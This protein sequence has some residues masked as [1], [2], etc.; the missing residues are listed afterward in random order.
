MRPLVTVAGRLDEDPPTASMSCPT[1]N[2][3]ARDL[4]WGGYGRGGVWGWEELHDR[5]D[6]W[7]HHT[8]K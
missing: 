1:V 4:G 3:R 7:D 2:A 6:P 8:V 5:D